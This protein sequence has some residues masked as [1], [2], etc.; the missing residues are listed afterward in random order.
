MDF[1][2]YSLLTKKP[3][4]MQRLDILDLLQPSAGHQNF[5]PQ[6]LKV[7]AALLRVALED[8]EERGG[9]ERVGVK[10]QL[11]DDQ[12]RARAGISSPPLSAIDDI[13]AASMVDKTATKGCGGLY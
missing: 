9:G 10:V 3:T 1:G 11:S 13:A 12:I 2:I 4:E 5:P 6:L 7:L 8:D